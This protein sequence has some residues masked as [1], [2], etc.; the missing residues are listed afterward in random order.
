[1]GRQKAKNGGKASYAIAT[2]SGKSIA[3]LCRCLRHG[4]CPHFSLTISLGD[5]VIKNSR[6]SSFRKPPEITFA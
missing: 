3:V 4:F 5:G 1:V 2:N 6:L